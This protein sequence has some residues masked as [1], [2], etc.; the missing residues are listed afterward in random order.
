MQPQQI[1]NYNVGK[2]MW[3]K[4]R[5]WLRRSHS[6]D[7]LQLAPP[8]RFD[9]S[10]EDLTAQQVQ[11]GWRRFWSLRENQFN[12]FNFRTNETMWSPPLIHPE[13][14]QFF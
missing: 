8:A 12:F 1:Q 9:P 6:T 5:G 3:E 7:Q 4:N 13:V 11:Q 14:S 2:I 10:V